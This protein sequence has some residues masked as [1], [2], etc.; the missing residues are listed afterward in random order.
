[1]VGVGE[2]Q[3][4]ALSAMLRQIILLAQAPQQARTLAFWFCCSVV[5][6][7]VGIS[8]SFFCLNNIYRMV[9]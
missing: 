5:D 7:A 1:M 6:L 3:K 9:S 8:P 4:P 2:L